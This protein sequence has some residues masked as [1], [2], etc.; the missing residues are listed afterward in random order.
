MKNI[1]R[2]IGER[3]NYLWRADATARRV[4]LVHF[5]YL[6]WC[7]TSRQ[8]KSCPYCGNPATQRFGKIHLVTELRKC[9]ACN[10]RFRWPKEEE[11]YNRYFYQWA[12]REVGATDMP[13]P[14]KLLAMKSQNFKGSR[15]DFSEK[16]ELVRAICP[17]GKLLDF[18][19]SWGYV[20]YQFSQAGFSPVGFELSKPRASFGRTHL[21]VNIIEDFSSLTSHKGTFDIAFAS[22]VLEHIPT[23]AQTLDLICSLLKP[24]GILILFVPNCDGLNARKEGMRWGPLFG[25]PHVLSLDKHFFSKA[26]PRQGFDTPLFF[27]E[28]YDPA[29]IAQRIKEKKDFGD[30]PGDELMMYAQKPMS[31]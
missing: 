18:G 9:S 20:T 28:P 15:Q 25:M 26:L 12:Y 19:A 2:L 6:I 16:V 8:N 1:F 29:V 13:E 4:V 21:G 31:P 22:H 30:P 23:P 5:A 27:S 14:D 3:L 7:V 17:E 10:L 24:G 11:Q